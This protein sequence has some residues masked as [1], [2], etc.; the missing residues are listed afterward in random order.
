[1]GK[2]FVRAVGVA[3]VIGAVFEMSAGVG[4]VATPLPLVAQ[5]TGGVMLA[6]GLDDFIAGARTLVSG[7]PADTF[8]K[9]VAQKIAL[10]AGATPDAASTIATVVDV[11]VG[12]APA[13]GLQLSRWGAIAADSK[14]SIS[15]AYEPHNWKT[16]GRLRIGAQS[17]GHLVW[18]QG[19]YESS[20]PRLFALRDASAPTKPRSFL[21]VAVSQKDI[22]RAYWPIGYLLNE[23]MWPVT[24]FGR[25]CASNAWL[26]TNTAGIASPV[27]GALSPALL[28]FSIRHGFALT[29]IAT[30]TSDIAKKSLG[31]L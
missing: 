6:H 8:T 9:T 16:A 10:A 14:N 2:T 25:T 27:W 23:P 19:K 22:D 12:I 21:S 4:V 11:T 13:M 24:V 30:V 3:E 5:V 26:L 7:K 28:P 20:S 31:P 29:G 1:M 18:Y 15:L 17:D